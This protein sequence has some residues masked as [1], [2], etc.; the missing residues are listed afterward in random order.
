MMERSKREGLRVCRV[1]WLV[2]VS[3]REYRSFEA[4]RA[5]PDFETWDR[6]CKLY[7]L[8]ADVRGDVGFRAMDTS[9]PGQPKFSRRE[10]EL[11][12]LKVRGM[13]T[14]EVAAYLGTS[15]A[16]ATQPHREDRPEDR[17]RSPPASGLQMNDRL[18]R[19]YGWPQT[20]V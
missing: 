12:R 8:A 7:G 13:S 9:E 15:R 1:A 6:I 19:L 10:K 20:L 16:N 14:R 3:I 4:G 5:F 18:C 11:L 17:W 2:G